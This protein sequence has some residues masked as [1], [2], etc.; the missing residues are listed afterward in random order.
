MKNDAPTHVLAVPNVRRFIAFRVFFNARF[1]YPIFTILFVD[2]GLTLAQ[3]ATL[4]AVWAATIVVLEVPSGA[5]A[6]IL[7]R[8]RLLVV[9]SAIMVVEVALLCL[10][11]RDRPA[12]LF[13]VFLVNRILS[14]C[15]EAAA[16]GADE[17]IAYDSLKAAGLEAAWGRV[18][19]IQMRVQAAGHILA[20]TIGAA[21]YDPA[22]MSPVARWLNLKAVL[23]QVDTLRLPLWLTLI[24]ALGALWTTLGMKEPRHD[25]D[26]A[27]KPIPVAEAFKTTLAAGRWILTTPFALAVIVTGMFF[28][29]VIRMILTLSSQ[30]YRLIQ[31]PEASFGLIGSAMA[32]LG[33]LVPRL[34]RIMTERLPPAANFLI[35]GL[36]GLVGLVALVPA[37]PLL[38]VIPMAMLITTMYLN[39][40]FQSHYLNRIAD[41]GRRAT[42]LSFKGLSFNLA[43]GSIGL[44]YAG[45]LNRLQDGA[46]TLEQASAGAENA[47][48]AGS[49]IWFPA[50]FVVGAVILAVFLRHRLQAMPEGSR[51]EP[52]RRS[53]GR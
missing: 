44:L 20:M 23:T 21:V 29:H 16:S 53:P 4:N 52:E 28:D 1:Y 33:L 45:L 18:L 31:L 42:I 49:L 47:V 50:Y 10:A 14:G 3:F 19:E 6:D 26:R 41:S 51:V 15:A 17:A 12:L 5:L 9:T 11:P 39:G 40:Y 25:S 22:I 37:V 24:M 32:G 7:G 48:F 30:Y 13:A 36:V 2:F 35:M 27:G 38:G 8:R 43:Y 46:G 34:A